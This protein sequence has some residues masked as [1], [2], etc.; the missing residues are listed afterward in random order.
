MH[1]VG[2]RSSGVYW[3]RRAL[4]AALAVVLVVGV[5][6]FVVDR[7]KGSGVNPASDNIA[8]GTTSMTGVLTPTTDSMTASSSAGDGTSSTTSS[9]TRGT[10]GS[11]QTSTTA[12]STGSAGTTA[13]ST[14]GTST[15]SSRSTASTRT[16]GTVSTTATRTT[17]RAGTTTPKATPTKKASTTRTTPPPK[18]SYDSHGNLLCPDS[19]IAIKATTGSPSFPVGS[20]P[21]LGMTVTNTGSKPCVR[22][23]SGPLQVY[24]VYTKAGKRIWSTADCF[25]GQGS[26][27]RQLAPGQTVA[28]T[29]RWSGT[30]STPGCATARVRVGAGSYMLVAD[31]GK[32]ASA[33]K[34]FAMTG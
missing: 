14:T 28:Y 34:P 2:P 29:V 23:L 6:W 17:G 22:D 21:I 15:S 30:T 33:P 26:D 19:A 10:T 12:S 18:P 27:I 25:P 3:V 16:T 4:V 24:T 8:A 11:T 7:G 32:L 1:P 5:A 9:S 20:Q 31:L 13:S